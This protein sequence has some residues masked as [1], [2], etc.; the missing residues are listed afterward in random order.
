M[1]PAVFLTLVLAQPT[2]AEG[3]VF[4]VT[5][6]GRKPERLLW[7][8]SSATPAYTLQELLACRANPDKRGC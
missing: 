5:V 3:S 1:A 4:R 2:T 8:S 6:H 7:D